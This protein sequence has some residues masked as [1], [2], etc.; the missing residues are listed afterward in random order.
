M[1]NRAAVIVFGCG[2]TMLTSIA[3]AAQP[4]GAYLD[5]GSSKLGVI[6]LHGRHG[7]NG[8][9]KS[10]VVNP[11]RIAMHEHLG[12]H[13]LSLEYPQTYQSRDAAEEVVHF[14]AAY[15]RIDAAIAFLTKEKGVTQI[16]LMGHSLGVLISTSYLAKNPESAVKGFI[17]VGIVGKSPNCDEGDM[18]PHY[19]LCNIKAML[20]NNVNFP[21]IDVVAMGESPD[22]RFAERRMNFVSSTYRQVRVEGADHSF[23]RKDRED[24]MVNIILAW[25]KQQT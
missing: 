21:V 2:I 19:P 24:E 7:G 23:T 1:F 20:K 3:W 11:L 10:P 18:K 17:G 13:T 4:D 9:A 14:P 22:V 15:Q 25:L 6:L 8:H 5:G 16:Y 12:F